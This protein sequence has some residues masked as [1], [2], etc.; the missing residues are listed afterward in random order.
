MAYLDDL[1]FEGVSHAVLLR[2]PHA[3]ARIERTD[4]SAARASVGVPAVLTAQDVTADGLSPLA[5]PVE[6]NTR[7]GEPF[8]VLPQPLFGDDVVRFVGEPAPLIIA[9]THAQ[10]LDAA[11]RVE[12]DYAPAQAVVTPD[13]AW[14]PRRRR[15]PMP[16]SARWRRSASPISMAPRHRPECGRRCAGEFG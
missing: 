11:E 12:V 2:S 3:H 5:L 13:E 1:A 14:S 6:A 10:A 7:T 8:S 16:S 9:E 15:S 4:V